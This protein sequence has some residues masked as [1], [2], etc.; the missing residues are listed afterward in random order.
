MAAIPSHKESMDRLG[1]FVEDENSASTEG[2]VWNECM[3]SWRR[4]HPDWTIHLWTNDASKQFVQTH[5]STHVSNAFSHAMDQAQHGMASDILRLQLLY[6]L[7]GIYVDVDY[8]CVSSIDELLSDDEFICGA[9]HTHRVELNNG[10]LASRPGHDL[11]QQMLLDISSW[12][13]QI[14]QN[15][16]I[17]EQSPLS[18]FLDASSIASLAKARPKN[19]SYNVVIQHTG[20]GLL[21]KVLAR[22][23][24]HKDKYPDKLNR[25][26][27]V[28]AQVFHPLSNQLRNGHSEDDKEIKPL[29]MDPAITKAVHLWGC[30]WQT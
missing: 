17:V 4:H 12:W 30:S 6:T 29:L 21:T 1:L 22:A 7:G 2:E 11:V 19:I 15:L 13:E 9:S 16:G 27:I 10:F 23:L 26:A 14:I 18:A 24:L 28:P 5:S 20:P 8:W 25:V 3:K